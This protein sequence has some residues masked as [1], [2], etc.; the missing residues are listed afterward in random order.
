MPDQPARHQ[1]PWITPY[2]TPSLIAAIAYQG[3]PA[4]EDP[5]WRESGAPDSEA[6]GRWCTRLCGMACL[7]IALITSAV[8]QLTRTYRRDRGKFW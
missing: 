1:V 5:G 6:Y 4:A 8:S 3:H 7:R 2:A